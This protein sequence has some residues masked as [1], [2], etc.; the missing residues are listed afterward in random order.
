MRQRVAGCVAGIVAVLGWEALTATSHPTLYVRPY[1][2]P[3]DPLVALSEGVVGVTAPERPRPESSRLGG[4][5][6]HVRVASAADLPEPS[7]APCEV[8]AALCD[9]VSAPLAAGAYV[10]AGAAPSPGSAC[11][12]TGPG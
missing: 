12:G 5:N 4:A 11:G 3:E 6:A 2:P 1:E 9:D 7:T 8:A 10:D